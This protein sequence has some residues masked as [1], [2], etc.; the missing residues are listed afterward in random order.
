MAQYSVRPLGY[1]VMKFDTERTRY[2]SNHNKLILLKFFSL[3]RGLSHNLVSIL[4]SS[5]I[6]R[7]LLL[8][9]AIYPLQ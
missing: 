3:V 5:A 4:Q 9:Y 1:G 6:G 8:R 2:A 7:P